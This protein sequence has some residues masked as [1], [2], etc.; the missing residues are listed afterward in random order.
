MRTRQKCS[1]APFSHCSR[2]DSALV[3]SCSFLALFSNLLGPQPRDHPNIVRYLGHEVAQDQAS[4]YIFMEYCSGGDLRSVL[5]SFGGVAQAVASNYTRQVVE[6]L[7]YLHDHD[8]L[9]RDIKGANVLLFASGVCKL[10]DFGLARAV[11]SIV[12]P[13]GPGKSVAGTPFWMAPEVIQGRGTSRNSD[14]WSLGATVFEMGE[15]K[16]PFSELEPTAALFYIGSVG[17]LSQPVPEG[18]GADG[19][20][21][22]TV[23]MSKDPVLRPS[24]RELLQHPF[25]S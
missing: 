17:L 15:G 18:L 13:G 4:A 7:G 14:I 3:L 10:G 8:V 23:C 21:F 24:C 2:A 19:K 11:A 12:P 16:P 6:G 5:R 22:V 25:L 9:H 20:D 1:S